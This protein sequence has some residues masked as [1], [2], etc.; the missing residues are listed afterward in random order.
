MPQCLNKLLAHIFL[1]EYIDVSLIVHSRK[2]GYDLHL[3]LPILKGKLQTWRLKFKVAANVT[4][5]E[6]FNR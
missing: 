1:H 2:S 4:R 6:Y 5:K 3:P